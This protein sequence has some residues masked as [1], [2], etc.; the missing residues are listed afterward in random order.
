MAAPR[1]CR[2]ATS[3]CTL[4]GLNNLHDWNISRQIWYGHRIPAWFKDGEIKV[5]IE[6]PGDGWQQD[7]DTLDTWFSSGLWT[8]STLGWPE[9]TKDFETYHPTSVLET[10]DD[11]LFFWVARMILMTTYFTGEVPFKHVYLHGM[12]RDEQ[13]KKM[14]K[15]KGNTVDPLDL[16]EKYGADATRLSLIVGAPPGNDIPLGEDKVRA[17]KKFANKLWNITRFVL[18]NTQDY[19]GNPEHTEADQ[20]LENEQLFPVVAEVTKHIEDFRLDL[21]ADTLYHFVWDH[22]A[23][24]VIED[25]KPLLASDDPLVRSSRQK[26]LLHYLSYSLRM[27]HPFMPFITEAIW[28]E[29]PKTI[30]ERDQLMVT[31]WPQVK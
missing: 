29:M 23:S 20:Q 19:D 5:Q 28:Q 11:I 30:R 17:Y 10:G 8:M 18:E 15:S 25:S 31:Q 14:S 4:I 12:V 26:L 2:N 24:E 9:Q 21:A 6:S 22:F 3:E 1:S 27:L 7:E 16:I 13:G